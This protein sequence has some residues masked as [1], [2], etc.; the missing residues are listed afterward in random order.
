M[1]KRKIKKS[2]TIKPYEASKKCIL[3][4]RYM[5]KPY[6]AASFRMLLKSSGL[7]MA[8][9]SITPIS[10]IIPAKYASALSVL[11]LVEQRFPTPK[12]RLSKS[13]VRSIV[14]LWR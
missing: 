9:A 12:V 5:R 6:P 4:R 10:W 8:L 11:T 13:I 1:R 2:M 3:I 7:C 14:T